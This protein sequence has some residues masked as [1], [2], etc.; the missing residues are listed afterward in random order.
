MNMFNSSVTTDGAYLYFYV[1]APKT[2]MF[3]I[4][5]GYQGTTLGKVYLF[6]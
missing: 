1:G 6:H 3:K 5:T 2:G 4:G